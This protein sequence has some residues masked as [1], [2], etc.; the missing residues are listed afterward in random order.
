[1]IQTAELDLVFTEREYEERLRG[2]RARMAEKEV[3]TLLVHIPENICYLTGLRSC[4]YY[5]YQC[6]VVPLA[7]ECFLVMRLLESTNVE[8]GQSWVR[9][10]IAYRDFADPLVMLRDE[11][12]SRGLLQ[13]RIGIEMDSWFLTPQRYKQ[14]EE[15]LSPHADVVDA[16][17][18]VE[19]G[20]LIKSPQEIEY[21]EAGSRAACAGM[22]AALDTI[23]SGRTEDDVARAVHDAAIAAGS[24]WMSISPFVTAG[25]RSGICHTTWDGNVIG[26]GDVVLLE[27]SGAKKRYSGAIMRS[28]SVGEPSAQVR[29]AADASLGALNAAIAAMRPG[30]RATDVDAAC[31]GAMDDAGFGRFFM[32]RTGYSLGISFPPDWGEGHI[33]SLRAGEERVL[34]PGMVFHLVPVILMVG[35]GGIA[36][37]ETVQVTEDGV[38]VL[39]DIPRELP[40]CPV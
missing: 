39:G 13:G 30:V 20:R 35:V 21:I 18:T 38:R 17:M 36:F 4:G 27:I 32:N 26:A 16:S 6:L 34:E 19:L 37:S 40:I 29:A 1:M 12:R 7:G 3:D 11:L 24:E 9:D 10:F 15:L 8:G 22:K 5:M 25:A 2:V 14:L 33:M 23:T 28:A 31:R